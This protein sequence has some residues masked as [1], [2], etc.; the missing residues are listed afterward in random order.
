MK[1]FAVEL[2]NGVEV[3]WDGVTRAYIDAPSKFKGQTKVKKQTK[4]K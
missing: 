1:P 3:W 2:P 4:Q